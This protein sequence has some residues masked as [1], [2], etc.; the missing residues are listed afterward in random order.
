MYGMR[1]Y[2]LAAAALGLLGSVNMANP[3]GLPPGRGY[4]PSVKKTYRGQPIQY[5]PPT[6]IGNRYTPNGK[7]EVARRLR[8][9]ESGQLQVSK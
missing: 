3:V 9:I 2:G 8:Q 6:V 7:R 5:T 4:R 1:G